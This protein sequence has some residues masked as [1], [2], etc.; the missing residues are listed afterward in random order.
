MTAILPHCGV[1]L[2]HVGVLALEHLLG[3]ALADHRVDLAAGRPDVLEEDL[4]A[5]LVDA[6]RLLGDVDVHRAGDRVGDDQR[7]RGEIVRAHVGVDAAFEVAVAG[8]HRGGDQIVLVDRFGDFLRQRPGVAD[9]GGAAEA[10][11]VEAERV[12]ILLQARLLVIVGDHL[13]ARRQRGLHPRLHLEAL[14]D[15]LAGEQAGRDH[16]AR[17][18]GVGAGGDRGDHHVAV[19]EIVALPARPRRPA[20]PCQRLHV[21]VLPRRPC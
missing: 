15:R 2:E 12:E 5:L 11:Q 3:D 7:R 17:V 1:A 21:A 9:A 19:A 16:H 4:L 18:R 20:N 13:R 14:G 8:Q 6:E 10:D